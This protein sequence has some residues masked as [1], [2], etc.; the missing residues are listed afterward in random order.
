MGKGWIIGAA[1]AGLADQRRDRPSER[2]RPD[3]RAVL[4]MAGRTGRE[5]LALG[6]VRQGTPFRCTAT[7][8]FEGRSGSGKRNER[9]ACA[10]MFAKA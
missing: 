7:A 8:H 3:G 2:I 4:T 1:A 10:F 6:H 9:R 5:R